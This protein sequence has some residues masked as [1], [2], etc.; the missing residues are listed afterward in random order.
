MPRHARP[1]PVHSFRFW[2]L[3][4]VAIGAT[5]AW[6]LEL[7]PVGAARSR[8]VPPADEVR[9]GESSGAEMPFDADADI[10]LMQSEPATPGGAASAQPPSSPPVRAMPRSESVAQSPFGPA[11]PEF[12]PMPVESTT[13]APA[14]SAAPPGVAV[15]GAGEVPARPVV[16]AGNEEA[17]AAPAEPVVAR[18]D[19]TAPPPAFDFSEIDVHLNAGTKEGDIAAHRALSELYWQ[20]PELRPQLMDRINQTARRIYFQPQPHYFDEYLVQQGETLQGIARRYS[21]S[22]EYLERL[23]RIQAPRMRAGQTLKVI[24]G[25]F[26]A[27]IDLSDYDLTIHCHGHYVYHFP[28]GIGRD[29]STPIGTFTVEDKVVNPPYNGPEGAIAAD[30]PANPIGERWISL[31]NG[32]GIH[33]TIEPDS[34]GKAASRGCIRMH[35]SDVEI[36]YDL[37]TVGSE[38]VIQR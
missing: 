10:F 36:V 28:I 1:H 2:F 25:P 4:L 17:P 38:V 18:A 23:N 26:G 32:Y 7:L 33:G 13:A 6:K 35:N 27:V 24:K 8:P 21:V 3:V 34:I 14:P 31:G 20:R 15:T 37:L 30:D 12:V 16:L 22:W 9:L 5:A 19:A 11:A 29:G